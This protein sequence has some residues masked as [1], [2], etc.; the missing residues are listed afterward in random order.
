M[1]WEAWDKADA[2]YAIKKRGLLAAHCGD[3]Q[4]LTW[5][6][7][8]IP[9]IELFA[10]REQAQMAI[11]CLGGDLRGSTIVKVFWNGSSW[12]EPDYAGRPGV[13]ELLVITAAFLLLYA[14]LCLS[15]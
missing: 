9:Y 5:M 14:I 10:T 3:G 12:E 15:N 8:R 1:E 6:D 7:R 13:V 2:R 4:N 11:D